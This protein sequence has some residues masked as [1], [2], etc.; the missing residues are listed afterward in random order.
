MQQ[1]LKI[2]IFGQNNCAGCRD[3]KNL[4]HSHKLGYV[5]YNIQTNPES[6]QE[7]FKRLPSARSV[8]QIFVNGEHIGGF[9]ELKQRLG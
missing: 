2:E 5:E 4:L 8:P 1:E 3:A 6:K 9:A 7:L